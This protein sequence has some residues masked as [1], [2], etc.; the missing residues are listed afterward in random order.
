MSK[1][2]VRGLF[3]RTACV[4]LCSISPQKSRGENGAVADLNMA[5]DALAAFDATCPGRGMDL[6][7]DDTNHFPMA[8][9]LYA[10]A[11][12]EIG[13]M[14]NAIGAA[15]WLMTHSDEDNDG[16]V[17]WGLPFAWDAF[18]D[19]TEN[20]AH[21]EYGITTVWCVRALLDVYEQA[22]DENALRVALSA[23]DGYL[24]YY[25]RTDKGG[26]FWYSSRIE[27]ATGVHNVSSMLMSQYARAYRL[28]GR[29]QYLSLASE[30][31]QFLAEAR[32]CSEYGTYW[33]YSTR[34]KRYNDSKH[35]AYIVQGLV[36]FNRYSGHEFFDI[37][38]SVD[39][40]RRYVEDELTHEFADCSLTP[41]RYRKMPA[42]GWGC[43]MLIYTLSEVG[44]FGAARV[45]VRT[46]KDY[47]F[48][49]A[50]YAVKPGETKYTPRTQGHVAL[51][52]ARFMKENTAH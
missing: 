2:D 43:G 25:T 4:L 26:F 42:R 23:L 30:T 12:C 47:R 18:G 49:G 16:V 13:D 32:L 39:Y 52:L 51:G 9:A 36:D 14:T 8:Y 24:Q 46:L 1:S 28:T 29:R 15:N 35:A 5:M 34:R 33:F 45:A 22:N 10:S 31:A 3:V 48:R 50:C 41:T 19:G 44:D 17:G 37:T 11:C 38:G 20:P 7:R 6:Y 27:D 40:L 21:T